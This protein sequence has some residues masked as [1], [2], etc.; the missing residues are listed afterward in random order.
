MSHRNFNGLCLNVER[1]KEWGTKNFESREQHIHTWKTWQ[2]SC[3]CTIFC[4]WIWKSLYWIALLWTSG[5]ITWNLGRL[6]LKCDGTRAETRFHLSCETDGVHL[7]RRRPGRQF[8]R[9]LAAEVCASAVVMLDTPC[10]EV[11]WRVLAT[12]L[13]SPVS[14]LHFDLPCVTVCHHILTGLYVKACL[15]SCWNHGSSAQKPT[16]LCPHKTVCTRQHEYQLY[17]S[18]NNLVLQ[19][20]TPCSFVVIMLHSVRQHSHFV[21]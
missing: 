15:D 7:N 20:M 16:A 4:C 2:S 14:P 17:L 8:S 18:T 11:V 21:V 12:P 1:L 19:V 13:H 5:A 9:I 3:T 10:S 6:R